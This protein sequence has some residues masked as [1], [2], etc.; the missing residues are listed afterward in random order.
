MI[1]RTFSI[2]KPDAVKRN[3]IGKINSMLEDAGF[4]IIAMK[5]IH[6]TK[7]Q[8][9]G[10]YLVH[11]DRPFYQELTTQMSAS[12]VV[13]QVLEKEN[14]VADYRKIMGATN[15]ANAEEGTIRAK[16]ALSTGENSVHGSDCLENAKT[17]I[18][19]FFTESEICER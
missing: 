7:E 11:K 4:K 12:P 18:N 6:M 9:E 14:A 2:I 1:E 16:Y 3:L 13:V 19:Y 17:E 10:F 8:A 5:M 15:P